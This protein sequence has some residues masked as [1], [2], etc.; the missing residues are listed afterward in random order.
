MDRGTRRSSRLNHMSTWNETESWR[1]ACPW[2]DSLL[3][4]KMLKS[5]STPNSSLGRMACDVQQYLPKALA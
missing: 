5:N 3:N 1:L 4:T 2:C